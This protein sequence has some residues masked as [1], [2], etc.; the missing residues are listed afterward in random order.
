MSL[1]RGRRSC[2]RCPCPLKGHF[3]PV[4]LCLFDYFNSWRRNQCSP[5]IP[6]LLPSVSTHSRFCRSWSR[7][8]RNTW[9]TLAMALAPQKAGKSSRVTAMLCPM[10]WAELPWRSRIL[11]PIPSIT[12]DSDCHSSVL[13]GTAAAGKCHFGQTGQWERL[14]SCRGASFIF[15]WTLLKFPSAVLPG[16]AQAP[17]RNIFPWGH[18]Q[19]SLEISH[20]QSKLSFGDSWPRVTELH[21]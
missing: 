19:L 13:S 21:P 5:L 4:I 16:K 17:S 20:G 9:W 14:P 1:L 3:Q 7:C 10:G 12:P 11:I 6:N 15:L 18:C 8:R 2:G